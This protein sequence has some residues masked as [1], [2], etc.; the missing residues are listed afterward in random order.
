MS[1]SA[2]AEGLDQGF[3]QRLY[4]A[5]WRWH[6]YAGLI[7]LPF[8]VVLATTGLIMVYGNSIETFLGKKH[9]IAPGGERARI[10]AQAE[11]A[12]AAVPGGTLKL[13]VSPP[14]EDRAPVFIVNA[15]EREIIVPVDPHGPK[16]LETVAREDTW[17]R[18]ASAIHGTLMIGDAGDVMLEVAAGLGI[19][20]VITGLYLWWPRGERG[21][22]RVLLPNLALSDRAFWKELHVSIGFYASVVLLFFFV[23]GLSWTMVWGTKY[24]QAWSTFPAAKWDSVPL[25]DKKHADMN[26]DAKKEVPWALEQTPLPESGSQAG[27]TGLPPG[28]A[29]TLDTL[30]PFARSIGF[31]EQF[32]INAPGSA[33]GVYTISADSM[34]ADTSSPTGDRTMHIDQYTG[35]ILADVRFGDYSLPGKAMAVGIALHQGN[36]GL[37]NTALNTVFCL[38]VI[39]MAVSGAVMWWK[40]RPAGELGAPLYPRDYRAP[41]AILAIAALVAAMFPLT[42]LSLIVFAVIDV[43]LPKRLKEAGY[44]RA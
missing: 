4:R 1:M 22:A 25:S 21:L 7:V 23:T 15:N 41:K 43:L 5:V 28:T 30:A 35:K 16:A 32:R 6:F 9:Y 8:L 20:L 26:H 38:A 39:F 40:R 27:V 37:W 44:A 24:V 13:Y 18:W 33:E 14:A 3:N 17:Y 19:I 34:D 11:A 36:I 42:G 2:T 29:V 12:L 31:N 10:A